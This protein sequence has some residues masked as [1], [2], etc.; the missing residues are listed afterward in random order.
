MSD[1]VIDISAARKMEL[2]AKPCDTLA[3]QLFAIHTHCGSS[4]VRVVTATT[5]FLENMEQPYCR[6]LEIGNDACPI[7][8]GW[9]SKPGLMIIENTT[10]RVPRLTQPSGEELED[11][12]K[13]VLELL[14]NGS[15]TGLLIRPGGAPF[16]AD[17]Q[18]NEQ[19]SLRSLHGIV[20]AELTI[21]P[22]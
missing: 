7:D 5:D 18:R 20:T 6:R 15:P 22:R 14:V 17:L 13:R 1:P 9:L 12:K 16:M 3:L 2:R 10:L 8:R 4:P 11:A 21:F 19:L